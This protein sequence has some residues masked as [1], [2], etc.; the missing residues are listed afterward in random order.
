MI[1]NTP[2][3]LS[4]HSDGARI[5]AVATLKNIPLLTTLSA[6]LAAVTAIRA[7]KAKEL[8]YLSLQEHYARTMK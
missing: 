5:R 6:A 7:L 1:I 8:N 2:L 4:T 3:G